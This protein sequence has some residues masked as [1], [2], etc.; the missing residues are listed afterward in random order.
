MDHHHHH[1]FLL[2][3]TRLIFPD[4]VSTRST[5]RFRSTASSK[6]DLVE[7]EERNR[8]R[9]ASSWL[10]RGYRLTTTRTRSISQSRFQHHAVI[11]ELQEESKHVS[12]S[13]ISSKTNKA[14]CDLYLAIRSRATVQA[15]E[16]DR[17]LSG[18]SRILE[19]TRAIRSSR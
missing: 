18:Q 9:Q 14:I 1:L 17:Q 15:S 13:Y 5:F 10:V 11:T 4:S 7:Y 19:K 6:N 2:C 16:Q 3:P 8:A 12:R